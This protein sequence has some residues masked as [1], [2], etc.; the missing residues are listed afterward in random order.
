MTPNGYDNQR[1]VFMLCKRISHSVPLLPSR[2]IHWNNK[3]KHSHL[4]IWKSYFSTQKV[5]DYKGKI[6]SFLFFID[7][8]TPNQMAR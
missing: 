8:F 6:F 2:N 1:I 5:T 7:L 3:H 4:L